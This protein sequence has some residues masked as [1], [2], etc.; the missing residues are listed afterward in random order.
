MSSNVLAIDLGTTGIKVAVVDDTGVV[1]A[2]SGDVFPIVFTDDGGAE[3][4]PHLWWAALGRCACEAMQAS[5]LHASDVGLVAVTSQYTSTVAVDRAGNALANTI[6]WMDGRG[7]PH[8]HAKRDPESLGRWVDIHGLAPWGNDDVGH[9]GYLRD[10]HPD[11]Y[12]AAYAFVEPMDHLAGRL[13]GNVVATQ[14]T[15]FPML[16]TDNRTWGA[17]EYS[18]ELLA[19]SGLDPAKL[20]P[21]VPMG[22]PRGTVTPEA[23]EHL[24]ISPRAV[25]M[26]ATIDSVTTAVG[27]GALNASICGLSI[28]TTSVMVTHVPTKRA[29]LEHGLTTAPSP[30]DHQYFLVA[31]NGI[32]GKAFDVFV[33]NLVFAADGLGLDAPSDRFER[34]FAA[35]ATSPAGANGVLF[36][37]WLVGSMAPGS[38]RRVRGGFVNIGLETQRADMARAVLEGVAMN[39]A[40]LLPFFSALAANEYRSISFGAGGAGSALWGQ[41]LADVCGVEVRRLANPRTTNAHGAALLA[42][43]QAGQLTF[44]ELPSR[45]SVQQVHQPDPSTRRLHD[46]R[47]TA[48]IEFHDSSVPIYSALTS[49]EKH[50]S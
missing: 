28:G 8:N 1:L 45:L 43:A 13:T 26:D 9:V 21:L 38:Q 27:T 2:S 23:A 42:L 4:D 24:G 35:A 16:S 3:Q 19:M 34:A 11:V 39:A 10:V 20:A 17:T 14:C 32:G 15:M 6:M 40:W 37:P 31:E 36:L 49:R 12:A 22:T 33:N 29:D 47:L 44:A 25:V 48:F 46:A 41:M 30:L 18:P 50:T 7:A 5:G